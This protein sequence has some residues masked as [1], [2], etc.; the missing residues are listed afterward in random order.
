[1]INKTA[2]KKHKKPNMMKEK[3]KTISME[4]TTQ[5]KITQQ[6]NQKRMQKINN[7]KKTQNKKSLSDGVILNSIDYLVF[8][9]SPLVK[10]FSC[11][12]K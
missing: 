4:L 1:M 9:T 12:L 2:V 6:E 10:F 11:L 8:F 7:N 5:F 3:L